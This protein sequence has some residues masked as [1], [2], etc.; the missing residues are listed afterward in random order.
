[1]S[2]TRNERVELPDG[3]W[4]D[5]TV[6]AA[7]DGGPGILLLQ[8]IFGVGEFLLAKAQA[9]ADEGYVVACPDVFWR[10]ERNVVLGHDEASLPKA[11]AYMQRYSDEVPDDTKFG[12]LVAAL[13]HLRGL[14]EV[15]GRPTGVM[16]Y[17]LGGLLA[18]GVAARGEPDACVSYYG[19]G[20]ASRLDEA[21]AVRCPVLFHYGGDDP[22]IPATEVEQVTE[23]FAGRDDVEVHVHAGAGH[24]FEN[25]L[26]P[27]FHSPDATAAAWP[28]T[29]DFLRRTL[30]P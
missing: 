20:I 23:A 11:F 8:E 17:C 6:V 16:G 15:G 19:S 21:D 2:R 26:A 5:A 18:Y 10:V 28:I 7:D 12:D 1:V 9:L 3:Q 13:D 24:A 30:G 27:Q 4:F 25:F 22:F 29:L 14:P